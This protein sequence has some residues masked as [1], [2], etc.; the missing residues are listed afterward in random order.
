MKL[1]ITNLP[2]FYKINL[3]NRINEQIKIYVIF[4]GDT[5]SIR[6]KDF[7][8]GEIRFNYSHLSSDA[9]YRKVFEF[10]NILHQNKFEELIIGG[11]D[12]IY[13]WLAAFFPCSS[14]KSIVV[15]SSIL[16]SNT[17]GLKG[18]LK[19]FFLFRIA[20]AYVSGQSQKELLHA[21]NFKG[22]CITTKGVGIFN[23]RPQPKFEERN[24]IKNFL[25]VGR[26]SPEKNLQFLIETFNQ[27]PYLTLNIVGFGPQEDFLKSI[28][29]NNIIFHGAI[30]NAQLYDT[31]RK[32]D[33]FI[34][35]SISETW[36]LVVEEALNNGLPVIVSDHV[37]CAAEIIN[38][39]N[40]L[41]FELTNPES[42]KKTVTKMLNIDYYN[43]L[44][45]NISKLN[46]E[47]IAE[48]QVKCY[49]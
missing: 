45:L 23:V 25:Y 43:S 7:F 39:T 16:E 4:T 26:L 41:I 33:V 9:I 28:G 27:L 21:L 48:E 38:E 34:L 36:G 15:E 32:N 44:R 14:K 17:S 3:Y 20:V 47:E 12:S 24:T 6:N 37:G 40:G 22:K 10:I 49:L 8:E 29:G 31:Y 18:F 13:M 2:S 11:W 5:A 35:P 19:K 46:F 42:L 30:P 1:I